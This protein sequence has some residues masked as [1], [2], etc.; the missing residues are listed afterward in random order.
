MR[1]L[2]GYILHTIKPGDSLQR[3]QVIYKLQDWREIVFANKL[4]Y[5]YIVDDIE[6]SKQYKSNPKVACMGDKLLIPSWYYSAS[7]QFENKT[8]EDIQTVAYGSDLDVW[9]FDSEN[10][11]VMNLDTKG[12]LNPTED[13]DINIAKGIANLRQQ[14]M[15]RLATPVGSLTL[16][17]KFGSKIKNM[18]GF[19]GTKTNLIK[20]KLEV[21]RV[22]LSDFR[23]N[24]VKNLSVEMKNRQVI[25]SC[26]INPIAPYGG[27]FQF[28]TIV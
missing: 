6:K 28:D 12:E 21:Q 14:L 23:V 11:T 24:Q 20:M 15:I 13:G 4:E 25:I 1:N 26:W 7:P 27:G 3:L 17:P 16:H 5:P 9:N 18:V 10:K 19:R 2:N 8:E 22:I